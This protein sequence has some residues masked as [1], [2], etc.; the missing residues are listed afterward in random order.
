MMRERTGS[1]KTLLE[2]EAHTYINLC[3]REGLDEAAAWAW[4]E[5]EYAD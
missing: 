5:A 3:L 4:A 2:H 1:G